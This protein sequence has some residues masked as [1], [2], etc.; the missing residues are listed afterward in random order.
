MRRFRT[1]WR[2]WSGLVS[3]VIFLLGSG[4]HNEKVATVSGNLPDQ[5]VVEFRL[6]ESTSGQRLYTLV[7]DEAV[8]FDAEGRI[9]VRQPRITFYNERGDVHSILSA[10]AGAIF[11]KTEDLVAWGEV[12]V[13]TADSTVLITD[14]LAWSNRHRVV[15]TDAPVVIETTRGRVMGQGLIADAGLTKIEFLS[16]VRGSSSYEWAP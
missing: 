13:R 4:C 1:G 14:S 8:V 10:R 15:R 9:D 12:V 7:A 6:D 5:V 16:E 11:T 3:Q 2:W